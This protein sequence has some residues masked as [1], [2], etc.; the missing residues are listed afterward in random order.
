MMKCQRCKGRVFVDRVFSQKL[1]IELFCI[2]CGKRWMINKELNSFAKW[3]DQN[4]R[5]HA[6]NYSISS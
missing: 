4:D 5:A 3:L 2:L 1:H 6:K